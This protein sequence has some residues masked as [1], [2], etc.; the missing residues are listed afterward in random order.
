M[1]ALVFDLDGTLVDS[2]Y[3]HLASWTRAFRSLGLDL[4]VVEIHRRIGMNGSLML[5]ALDR[6]CHLGLTPEKK[7]SLEKAHA[8]HFAQERADVRTIDG[9][10][11]LSRRLLDLR[12][13]MAIATSAARSEAEEFLSQ[14][15][16]DRSVAIITSDDV[17]TSKPSGAQFER[18]FKS[19]GVDPHEAGIVG[20]STW[21]M[22]ASRQSGS[23]GVGVL[24]GGYSREELAASGGLRVFRDIAELL[25]RLPELGIA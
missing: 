4:P 5:E 1:K 25:A 12:I 14:L 17:E 22:L 24:T 10:D 21:D 23:F 2:T 16:L 9:A 19:L 11:E 7:A 18:A 3:Q 8:Q 13:G 15:R 6:A 20:D